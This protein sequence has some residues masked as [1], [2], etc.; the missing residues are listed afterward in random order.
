MV[1]KNAT[2]STRGAP[3]LLSAAGS[4]RDSAK[5]MRR[6]WDGQEGSPISDLRHS[7]TVFWTVTHSADVDRPWPVAPDHPTSLLVRNFITT[8]RCT[9]RYIFPTSNS[10]YEVVAAD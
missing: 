2:A 4:R 3:V 5:K 10:I 1:H 7:A 9:L 8:L 6:N